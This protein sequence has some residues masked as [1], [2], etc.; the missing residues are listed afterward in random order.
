MGYLPRQSF[1]QS[2]RPAASHVLLVQSPHVH[3]NMNTL[4]VL[5][6]CYDEHGSSDVSSASVA[7]TASCPGVSDLKACGCQGLRVR[8]EPMTE[9]RILDGFSPIIVMHDPERSTSDSNM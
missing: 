5:V 9:V 6:Q 7:I 4:A 2:R 8:R 3:P 1:S